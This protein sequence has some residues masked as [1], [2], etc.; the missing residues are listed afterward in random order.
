M[1][2]D[3]LEW[4]LSQ[5]LFPAHEVC[6]F[7]WTALLP[8]LASVGEEGP[9]PLQR[10]EVPGW[11]DIWG[12]GGAPAQRR[13]PVGWGKDYGRGDQERGS[14]GDVKGMIKKDK[15]NLAKKQS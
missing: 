1:G 13:S 11:R 12:L 15:E 7:S 4:R 2:P 9:S 6:S 8:C 3:Q 5:E 14:E 10:L